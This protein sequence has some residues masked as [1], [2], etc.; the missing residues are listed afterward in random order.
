MHLS[1]LAENDEVIAFFSYE[2]DRYESKGL[3]TSTDSFPSGLKTDHGFLDHG[4]TFV[5]IVPTHVY[6]E[7][8]KIVAAI[9]ENRDWTGEVHW[10]HLPRAEQEYLRCFPLEAWQIF[11]I[12]E[13]SDAEIAEYFFEKKVLKECWE[14]S[15]R[16]TKRLR[17][18]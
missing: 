16:Q 8:V 14:R 4:G 2:R 17:N 6:E 12:D 15:W 5:S 13:E 3:V 7:Q 1:R 9:G 11:D 18:W 10:D